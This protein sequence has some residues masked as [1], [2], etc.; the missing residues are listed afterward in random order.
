MFFLTSPLY[1]SSPLLN[2]KVH[3]RKNELIHGFLYYTRTDFMPFATLKIKCYKYQ[4]KTIINVLSSVSCKLDTRI[5]NRFW[6]YF[7]SRPKA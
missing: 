7:E 3:R 5:L 4:I 1:Y 2:W 6:P